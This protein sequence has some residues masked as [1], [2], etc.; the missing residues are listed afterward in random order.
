[1]INMN[2]PAQS[3]FHM[4]QKELLIDWMFAFSPAKNHTAKYCTDIS[5]VTLQS[6]IAPPCYALLRQPLTK[7]K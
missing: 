3:R 2:L 4:L 6:Y 5:G 1:M 7:Q